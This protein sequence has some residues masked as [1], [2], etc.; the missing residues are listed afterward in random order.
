MRIELLRKT[1]LLD[2]N[3]CGA[4]S[5][6]TSGHSVE[7]IRRLQSDGI[8]L[9]C[10]G[11]DNN[12]IF[13]MD[14]LRESGLTPD[15][16]TDN[17]LKT[18]DTYFYDIPVKRPA[19]LLKRP[20]EYYFI[21]TLGN[22]KYANE[23]RVQLLLNG[24]KDF[25]II[26]LNT[27]F[28]FDSCAVSGLKEMFFDAINDI[29]QD[30]DFAENHFNEA[31]YV[32]INPIKWWY[33]TF[34]FIT[35][36][37]GKERRKGIKLL[38]VGPGSGLESL[39]YQ[40]ALGC[41]LNWI[42][43]ERLQSCYNVSNNQ[44]LIDKYDIHVQVGYIEADE[45]TGEYDIIILTDVI[46]HFAY[47]PIITMKK[48]HRMLR[49]GG[50]LALSTPNQKTISNYESWRDL[51]EANDDAASVLRIT[52]TGHVY[53]YSSSELEELFAESG[54]QVELKKVST[55]LQYVLT[56]I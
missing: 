45:F 36:C 17:N 52:K 1:R 47:N 10:F 16:I 19:E 53:E 34:E 7:E 20:E 39:L 22:E 5:I 32:Y 37:Y 8:K 42:N 23:V 41:E 54:F 3:R 50:H 55:K 46:E 56:K 40:K 30:T 15:V 44:G 2:N 24:V 18:L 29:Y 14:T 31:R 49:R 9:V 27:V 48:L 25:A 6:F 21:V 35:Q 28:D 33:D 12:S 43:L 51:P 26:S 4:L 11:C 38:D 13:Y